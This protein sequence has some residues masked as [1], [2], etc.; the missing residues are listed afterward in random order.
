MAATT[1]MLDGGGAEAFSMRK[2]ADELGVS[3]AAVYHHF[4]PKRH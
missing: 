2:L 1:R 4:P 3:T